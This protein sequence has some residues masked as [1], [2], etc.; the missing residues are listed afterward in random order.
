MRPD[1]VHCI[2]KPY[3]DERRHTSLCGRTDRDFRFVGLDHVFMHTQTQGRL[4][5]CP[6]CIDAAIKILAEARYDPALHPDDEPEQ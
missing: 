4:L 5:A 2:A 6:E 3:A 1:F